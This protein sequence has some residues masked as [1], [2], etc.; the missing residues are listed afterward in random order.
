MPR[1]PTTRGGNVEPGGRKK[2]PKPSAKKAAPPPEAPDVEAVEHS[3]APKAPRRNPLFPVGVTYYPL[4]AETQS[5]SD[6]YS[7]EVEADL[8]TLADARMTLVRLLLSWKV[9]EPQVGQYDEDA[10]ARLDAIV[11]A[12]RGR[13]LQLILTFFADDRISELTDV[14]WGKRRDPRTDSYLIQREVALVQRVVNRYRSE[15]AIFAWEL[16]NESF[17]VDFTSVEDLTKWTCVLRE[18]IRE[19]DPDRPIVLSADPETLLR[20]SGVDPRSAIDECEFAFAHVTSSYR[21]YAAEGPIT[22]G[23]ATYLESFLLRSAARDMPVVLDEVGVHTLEY[24]PSEEA[25]QVR[26]ALYSALMNRAAAVMLRR[27]RDLETEHREPYF[28]DPFEVIVGVADNDATPKPSL[29]EVRDFA[30]VAARVD[31]RAY[32]PLTDRVAVV[33]PKERYAPLPNLAGLYDPRA[34][35]QAYISAKEAHAPVTIAREGDELAAYSVL[36]V[37]SA[38]ELEDATWERLSA[39][40]QGGGS[41]ILSFGGGDAHP[42]VRSIFGVEFLGDEGER[43]AMSCRVAQA[44]LLGPL[45][46]FDAP[47]AL[48]AYALLGHGGATVVATDAKGSPLVTLQQYGQGRA[49]FVAAPI[50]RALA[51]GDPWSAPAAARGMLRTIYGAVVRAAGCGMPLECDT[52]EVELALYT[53]ES[54]DILL[55]LNHSPRKLTATVTADRSVAGV[56]DVRGGPPAEVR[57]PSF[58]VPLGPNGA[59]SLRV[60]YM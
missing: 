44:E 54:D 20:S 57:A 46:S 56:A 42:A 38:F 41:L 21:A 37:P 55:M 12:A 32:T 25:A 48:P 6:W 4:E 33:I 18:A 11:A 8:A 28:I 39:Y 60:S 50:E 2:A 23:P 10:F 24:S 59:A 45:V 13:K 5:W 34:C 40:V 29:A 49:V 9:F 36:I 58:G 14:P 27:Y 17:L 51:Q 53:G 15:R 47:L 7:H 3:V 16:A 22:S 52:P 43:K 1:K 26:T 35:L 19:I 30:R 31:L